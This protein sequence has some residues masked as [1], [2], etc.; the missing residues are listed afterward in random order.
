METSKD[1]FRRLITEKRYQDAVVMLPGLVRQNLEDAT[2]LLNIAKQVDKIPA[3]FFEQS[4]FVSKRIA[5]LTGYSS[6]FISSLLKLFLITQKIYPSIFESDYGTFEQSIYGKSET[7]REFAPD[8]VYFCVGTDHLQ[9]N[10]PELEVNRWLGLWNKTNEFLGAEVIH[11]TFEEPLH[12]VFFNFE[13]RYRQSQTSYVREVNRLLAERAPRFVH[14]NDIN[15]LAGFYGRR[16]WRNEQH[17]DLSK[18]PVAYDF[19]PQY[20][21]SLAAVCSAIYG[22]SK[23][24]IVLDL[25]NTLWGGIIGDDGMANI[26][27][28]QDSGT[29]EAY[30]RFQAYLKALKNRGVLLAVCSKNEERLAQEPFIKHKDMVLRL[31]DISCFVA[32]W[33]PKSD[34]IVKIAKTLNIGLDS[35]VFVDDNPA[36]VEIIKQFL[37]EVEAIALPENPAD[38]TKALS[39]SYFFETVSIT[40]EDLQ[41][42]EQYQAKIQRENLLSTTT[43]YSAYLTSL[44][45]VAQLS[46]FQADDVPRITQLINKTNQ[47]NLTTRRYTETEVRALLTDKNA[48]TRTIR[49]SDKFGD[50]GLIS[51]FIGF[52]SKGGALEIDTWLMSCRVLKREVE[53]FLF[54]SLV[55]D[56]QNI[57]PGV[58]QILGKYIPTEK[59]ALVKD[60]LP[61]LGFRKVAENAESETEWRFDLENQAE[62]QALLSKELP[63]NHRV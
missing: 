43:D 14:F 40:A 23:K 18:V 34:N 17:Y 1:T 38:Y 63:I 51:V 28:G 9:F 31:E 57:R 39:Q 27:I 30:R 11:N 60:L 50:H 26:K 58:S 25:D 48:V 49:L 29:G 16:N 36:E 62:T 24:C 19:F 21:M 59:N 55:R 33:E 37:P 35:L 13:T 2:R 46:A 41:R 44:E 47:F 22:K 52:L 42:A 7:L 56:L 20:S 8:L 53:T 45:M 15:S 4:G 3:E 10:E 5:I 32:N 61:Q 54:Q 12:R 6:Q